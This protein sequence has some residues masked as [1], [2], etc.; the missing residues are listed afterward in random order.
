MVS[1]VKM[2]GCLFVMALLVATG[3]ILWWK[4]PGAVLDR[5]R[6]QQQLE[7]ALAECQP[8][9]ESASWQSA[10]A[11]VSSVLCCLKAL[12]EYSRFA[13][14]GGCDLRRHSL[15]LLSL[16]SNFLLLFPALC[17]VD[18]YIVDVKVTSVF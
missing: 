1:Q 15:V 18:L 3:S 17:S 2:S 10:A 9:F 5:T 14:L 13:A 12:E 4:Q 8:M 11:T 16:A 7:L 6:A